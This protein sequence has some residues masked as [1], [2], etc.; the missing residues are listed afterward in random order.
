MLFYNIWPIICHC[1]TLKTHYLLYIR[2]QYLNRG[3]L[4]DELCLIERIS[5]AIDLQLLLSLEYLEIIWDSCRYSP[6]FSCNL[7]SN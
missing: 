1:L 7:N 2:Y 6:C 5:T 3:L 4:T